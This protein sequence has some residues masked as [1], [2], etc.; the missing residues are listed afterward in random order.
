[1]AAYFDFVGSRNNTFGDIVIVELN[2]SGCFPAGKTGG[3]GGFPVYSYNAALQARRRL[4]EH[5][6][7]SKLEKSENNCLLSGT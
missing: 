5:R 4:N 3:G 2:K 6:A 1:M 7:F